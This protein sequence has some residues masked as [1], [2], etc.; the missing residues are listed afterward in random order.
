MKAKA[1]LLSIIM[2]TT[3]LAGCGAKEEAKAPAP[4]TQQ[5]QP[6]ATEKKADVVTTA[7]IVKET[8]AFEKALGKEGTWIIASLNDITSTKDLVLDGEFKNGKKDKD[9]KDVI[10]RKIALYTQ[11]ADK[12]VTDR[13][14]LTAPKLTIKS[15]NARIQSGT[16]K[17][18]LYVE[19]K[20]FQLVDAKVEGNV[21]FSSEEAKAG[22]KMDGT[23]SITGKQEVKK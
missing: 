17:G 5:T 20:D 4:A 15:P 16:F 2:A 22:F 9:G 3:V 21:Y 7:S 8:E 23:S 13:F 14:T 19:T 6:A 10:Q 11:D 12:K 1:I 18:D